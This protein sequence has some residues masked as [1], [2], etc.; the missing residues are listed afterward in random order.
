M[1]STLTIA[2]VILS[3]EQKRIVRGNI[4]TVERTAQVVGIVEL[5]RGQIVAVHIAV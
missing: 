3:D 2:A 5:I 1:H 4:D